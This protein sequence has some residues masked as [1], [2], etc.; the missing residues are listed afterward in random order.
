MYYHKVFGFTIASEIPLPELIKIDPTSTPHVTIHKREANRPPEDIP[1]TLYRPFIVL[2][3]STFYL[4]IK[5]KCQFL[6]TKKEEVT[7]V[8]VELIND[9]F[10]NDMYAYLYGSVITAVLQLNNTFALHASAV[11]VQGKLHLFCGISGIGKSTLAAQLNTRGYP[12]FSDDKCVLK[13]NEKEK[14]YYAVPTLQIVR[15]WDDAHELLDDDGFIHNPSPIIDKMDKHQYHIED[16]NMIKEP[17]PIAEISIMRRVKG[18][19][20]PSRIPLTGMK[21]MKL[22]RAQIHRIAY[23]NGFNKMTEV[24][25]FLA[26][27]AAQIPIYAVRK[28]KSTPVLEFVDFVESNLT[29][30]EA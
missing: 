22:L 13:W 17:Q 27:L 10:E 14:Q 24:H 4:K 6:V 16:K 7:E 8:S 1:E 30:N 12:I 5:D 19:V 23:I 28:T 26:H 15:L 29:P 3:E 20:K 21:K 25:K 11:L 9:E 18:D 2:N